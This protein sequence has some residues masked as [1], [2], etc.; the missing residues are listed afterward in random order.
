ME[1]QKLDPVV[2]QLRLVAIVEYSL[3]VMATVLPGAMRFSN[4]V[5]IPYCLFV[6]GYSVALLLLQEGT[7]IDRIFYSVVWSIVIFASLYSIGTVVPGFAILPLNAVIPILTMIIIV[8][9]HFNGR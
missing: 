8:Y 7:V 5:V 9:D 2:R 4:V 3:L 6:P 1:I